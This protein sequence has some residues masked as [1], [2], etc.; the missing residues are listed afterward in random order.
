MTSNTSRTSIPNQAAPP[1]RRTRPFVATASA[2]LQ[3]AVG[4]LTSVAGAIFSTAAGGGWYAG[5]VVFPMA[6]VAW[7]VAGIGL[8]RGSRSAHRLGIGMLVALFAFDLVKIVCYHE[9]AG[10]VFA[11]LT[12]IG[13]ALQ[14]NPSTQ[15]WVRDGVAR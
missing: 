8:L 11:A 4:S 7:W 13:L 5:T 15:T 6:L 14:L 10:Y 3:L 2:I 12:V 1:T 9:S